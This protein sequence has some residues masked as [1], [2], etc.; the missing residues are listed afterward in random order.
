[1][2]GDGLV[3]EWV[4]LGLVGIDESEGPGCGGG[5]LLAGGCGHS[6][7]SEFLFVI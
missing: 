4:C 2:R 1:M 6:F 3:V 5:Y 7:S